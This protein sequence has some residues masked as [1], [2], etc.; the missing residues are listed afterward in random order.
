MKAKHCLTFIIAFFLLGCSCTKKMASS[1]PREKS[2]LMTYLVAPNPPDADKALKRFIAISH[3]IVVE[4]PE[5]DLVNAYE[6]VLK[7]SKSIRCEVL[8][9]RVVSQT[10]SS[11]PRGE[12]ALRI[13]PGDL[14]KFFGFLKKS[15]TIV[16]HTTESEDKTAEAVDV[17]AQLKNRTELRDR[18]RSLLSKS[19]ASLKELVELERE[20]SDVQTQLDSTSTRRKVLANETEKVAVQV[21]F[22]AKSSVAGVFAP[23][24]DAFRNSTSVLSESLGAL[25]IFISAIIPW[26]VLIIPAI[27]IIAKLLRRRSRKA[28]PS[29]TNITED[30]K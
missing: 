25:V 22:R 9:S 24:G 13:D 28:K 20:L 30:K 23:I 18:L 4:T 27:W 16:E 5:S 12:L 1:L 15:A 29:S 17:E 19:S 2:E 10:S 26:L 21:E 7:F 6:S 3:R 8:N 14:D 11:P